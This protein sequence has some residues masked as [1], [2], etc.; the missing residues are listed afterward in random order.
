MIRAVQKLVLG[1]EALPEPER[2]EL[3]G[4]L[5]R[6]EATEPH[7]LPNDADLVGAAD[8]VFQDLDWREQEP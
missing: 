7:D 8:H 1:F 6:R 3:L 5:L 4:E 2:Q